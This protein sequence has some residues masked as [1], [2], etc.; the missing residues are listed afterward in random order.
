MS[1]LLEAEKAEQC[2]FLLF[3]FFASNKKLAQ[4]QSR[5]KAISLEGTSSLF[6]QLALNVDRN[7]VSLHEPTC[8]Q[9]APSYPVSAQLHV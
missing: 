6:C 3:A 2:K 7:Y 8:V 5:N 9:S 1:F 4:C